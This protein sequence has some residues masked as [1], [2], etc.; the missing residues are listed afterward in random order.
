V[1]RDLL[2][3]ASGGADVDYFRAPE[4]KWTPALVRLSAQ[5]GMQPLGWTVDTRDWTRPGTPGIV[6]S[7][8][9]HVRPGAIILFHDR[10]GPHDQTLVAITQLIPW[11]RSQGYSIVLPD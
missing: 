3:A 5:D 1:S 10:G 8:E 7:A 6:A 4:G 9:R 2:R 11:L